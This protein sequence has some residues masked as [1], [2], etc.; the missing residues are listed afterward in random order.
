MNARLLLVAAGI[1]LASAAPA[2]AAPEDVATAVSKEIMSPYCPGATL[3]DCPSQN[4]IELREEITGWAA[5]GMTKAEIIDRLEDE[6]GPSIRA[7]PRAE[8]SGLFAWVLP[9]LGLAVGGALAYA[10]LR[11]WTGAPGGTRPT[12][13]SSLSDEDRARVDRELDR[14][15]GPA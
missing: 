3:H 5:D 10:L 7:V 9:G 12:E 6:Y 2:A 14:L 8:G 1:L 11:R 4:A 15:R 13:E